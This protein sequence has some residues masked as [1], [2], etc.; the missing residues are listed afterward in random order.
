MPKRVLA[1]GTF[2]IFHP[3]H[4]FYLK[5]ARK[6]GDELHVIVARDSTVEH[7]KGR[8]PLNN[9]QNRLSAVKSLRYVDKAYLGKEG[10][11]FACLE[12]IRPHVICLGYD[13]TTFGKDLKKVLQ[14]RGINSEIEILPSF[15]PERHKTSRLRP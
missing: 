11:K 15:M 6:R 10:D 1:F 5:Q 2:D 14:E 9:E 12:E 13:Q 4:E 7:L 8:K 3:G